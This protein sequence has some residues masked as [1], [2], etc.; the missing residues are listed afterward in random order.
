MSDQEHMIEAVIDGHPAR[1]I[2]DLIGTPAF[3]AGYASGYT[4]GLEAG[5]PR[6]RRMADDEAAARH[7]HAQ[8]LVQAVGALPTAEE[9]EARRRPS[10]PGWLPASQP[11]PFMPSGDEREP[12][13]E[14]WETNP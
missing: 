3:E 2:L 9:L 5:V 1:V 7:H 8:Q 14:P 12:V 4:A 6:G 11:W 10:R 13:A